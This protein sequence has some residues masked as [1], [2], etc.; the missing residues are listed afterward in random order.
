MRVSKWEERLDQ[1]KILAENGLSYIEI[2]KI[3]KESPAA[4]ERAMQRYGVKRKLQAQKAVSI[5]NS[6]TEAEL[7]KLKEASEFNYKIKQAKQST[8]YKKPFKTIIAIADNHVPHQNVPVHRALFKLMDD[9]KPDGMYILGDFM[10]MEAVSHWLHEKDKRLTLENKRLQKDYVEGNVLLDEIDKRLPKGADK[11]FWYGNHERFYYDLIEK[12]PQLEGI[13][14]P[15][16]S[17]K[18]KERG[19]IVY[20]EINH[21]ER[22]GRLSICHGMYTSQNYVKKHIDE[23]KTNV[24]FAHLHSPRMMFE[25]S[26]AREIA[27]AGYCLGTMGD[28]NPAFM[29]NRPNKWQH[30]FGVLY[31]FDNGFFDVQLTRLVQGRFV[32]DGKLYD[33]N[34]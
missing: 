29:H 30:G 12:I 34:K 6:L 19:Y 5:Y 7:V 15:T 8:K 22:V 3:F 2:A 21:I 10:D 1:L 14:S 26:P 20:D 32:F 16:I 17:L 13:F 33:G 9:L 11:R 4:V 25:P 18:L 27:I 31:F 24:L 23:F 28:L